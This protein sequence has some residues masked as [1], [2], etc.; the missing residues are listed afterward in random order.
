MRKDEWKWR[1]SAERRYAEGISRLNKFI[2][3]AANQGQT[4]TEILEAINSIVMM[5]VW[6]DISAVEALKM[7]ERV[8]VDNAKTWRE[9]AR[10]SGK[11]R[12][13]YELLRAE[14]ANFGPFRKII[15]YN[16]ELIRSVPLRVGRDITA[17]TAERMV[18]GVRADSIIREVR[19]QA[20]HL[21]VKHARL[22]AR[23]EIS[24]A[25][26]AVTQARAVSIGVDWYVWRTSEDQRVRSSHK[27]MEGVV[28]NFHSPPSPEE[29]IGE[30]SAGFYGPGEI[31]NC[32]CYP[33]PIIDTSF[34]EFPRQVHRNGSISRLSRSQFETTA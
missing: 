29:L 26:T 18:E 33:E 2:R 23:T 19:A 12:E 17:L 15:E 16:A 4:I 10:R 5:P 3:S 25:S 8:R 1:G 27:H 14:T 32:R 20:P 13:I 6:R 22:I 28:C 24:K 21:T 31:Y 9:A 30:K 7:V 11:A 34:I